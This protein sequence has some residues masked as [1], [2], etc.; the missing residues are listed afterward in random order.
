MKGTKVLVTDNFALKAEIV[1]ENFD[2]VQSFVLATN[3][4]DCNSYAAKLGQI[5]TGWSCFKSPFKISNNGKGGKRMLI[6]YLQ[7]L[8]ALPTLAK[9][10]VANKYFTYS[11]DEFKDYVYKFDL[12]NPKDLR[13]VKVD[14]LG[15]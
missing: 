5:G 10:T 6:I 11:N 13:L 12:S 4:A 14:I 3:T 7:S 15:R 2:I 1:D 8:T 9:L